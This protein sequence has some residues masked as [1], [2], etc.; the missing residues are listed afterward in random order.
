ML[1]GEFQLLDL[2][3]SPTLMP[4]VNL[5]TSG[6][7]SAREGVMYSLTSTARPGIFP[8]ALP[9][10]LASW[11]SVSAS[12]GVDGQRGDPAVLGCDASGCRV[13]PHLSTAPRPI[14]PEASPEDIQTV[15]LEPAL[16]MDFTSAPILGP[17]MMAACDARGC[18]VEPLMGA[19]CY[20]FYS[21]Y[22]RT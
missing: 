10:W 14:M 18:H 5:R 22:F 11:S 2:S 4:D 6:D 20:G 21:L 12:A 13:L 17:G 7:A 9:A 16:V 8:V 15:F 3:R 1:D 19:R